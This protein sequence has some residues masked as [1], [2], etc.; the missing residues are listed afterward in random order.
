MS[1]QKICLLD[2]ALRKD[3][4]G[5]YQLELRLS[6]PNDDA[7]HAPCI[8]PCGPFDPKL[9]VRSEWDSGE[10]GSYGKL[11]GQALLGSKDVRDTY[12]RARDVTDDPDLALRI[13]LFVEP[14]AAELNA[15]RWETLGDP[16]TGE[17][18]FNG[19]N[20]YF[21]RIAADNNARAVRIRAKTLLRALVVIAN[22][23][24]LDQAS[25]QLAP[26]DVQTELATARLGLGDIPITVLASELMQSPPAGITVAGRASVEQICDTL[27]EGAYD[28]L[29]IVC[30]GAIDFPQKGAE[31]VLLLEN[32]NDGTMDLAPA[33]RFLLELKKLSVLPRLLVLASCQ[34]AGT[35]KS[36]DAAG[37]LN[38]LAPRLAEAGVAAIVAM[39]GAVPMDTVKKFMPIFFKQVRQHGFVDRAMS[40]ARGRIDNDFWRPVLYMRLRDGCLW[41]VPGFSDDGG[42]QRLPALVDSIKRGGST[43]VLGPLLLEKYFGDWRELTRSLAMASG[44]PLA[45]SDAESLPSVAQ[46]VSIVQKKSF[47]R[48]WIKSRLAGILKGDANSDS[49]DSLPQLLSA[50]R[51]KA[52]AS[53]SSDPH[54]VLAQ[55][56]A[57]VFISATRDTL[58][59]DA[60]RNEGKKAPRTEFCRWR[61]SLE[62]ASFPAYPA[63]ESGYAPDVEHP[64]V[65]HL[66]GL[67]DVEESLVL[68]EDDFFDY[69]LAFNKDTSSRSIIPALVRRALVD[70]DLLFLGFR[71]E[72]WD[73]RVLYRCLMSLEGR[74]RSSDDDRQHVAAQIRPEEGRTLDP[75]RAR[76]Y[77]E[78]YFKPERINIYWGGVE[79]FVRDLD[80][81][82]HPEK[83]QAAS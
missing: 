57:K 55:C 60:L 59:E 25:I 72:V 41:Y 83:A 68:T 63:L 12:R 8:A 15:I 62:D 13:R 44:F 23:S 71:P 46:Y 27:R 80:L 19:E 69:L 31:P 20:I 43:P 77:F 36:S 70:S 3:V 16:D 24:N 7:V 67:W 6:D 74:E 1:D 58:L 32:K 51:E 38:A 61:P 42:Y 37:A 11:L 26:V 35:G 79:D 9:L 76:S 47:M 56:P 28:I 14:S 64:L 29:Y 17:A 5:Q 81:K 45:T 73:F 48:H 78:E 21:S 33:S 49:G 30:H 75:R 22:P 10:T 66:F 40:V 54:S 39:Q 34:G 2:L 52:R 50:A 53:R 18:L 65:Y 4:S 82:L